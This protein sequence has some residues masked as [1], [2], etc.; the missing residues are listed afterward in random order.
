M[1]EQELQERFSAYDPEDNGFINLDS[2]RRILHEY[3]KEYNVVLKIQEVT[4][5]S[6][7]F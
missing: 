4:K 6:I 5:E 2:F 3:A 1:N 7:F